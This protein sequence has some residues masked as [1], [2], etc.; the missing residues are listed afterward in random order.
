MTSHNW[1]EESSLHDKIRLDGRVSTFMRSQDV[2]GE[3][4]LCERL[5]EKGRTSWQD[6][7]TVDGRVKT[8]WQVKIGWKSPFFMTR[9][10]WM[11]RSRLHEWQDKT[12]WKSPGLGFLIRGLMGGRVKPL[13]MPESRRVRLKHEVGVG[14][15]F[16]TEDGILWSNKRVKL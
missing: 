7:T 16:N 15:A 14:Q 12:G 3:S 11:D 10:E 8:S 1:K 5:C 4:G 6:Q 13:R 9:I 2:K